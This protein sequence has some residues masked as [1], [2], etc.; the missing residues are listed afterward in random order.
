MAL[1]KSHKFYLQ[2]IICGKIHGTKSQWQSHEDAIDINISSIQTNLRGIVVLQ[3]L[4][5]L[6][7]IVVHYLY[8][9][10]NIKNIIIISIYIILLIISLISTYK[11]LTHVII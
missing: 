3:L 1:D 7:N 2:K 9:F 8:I 10:L 5:Q 6:N 11:L 4:L